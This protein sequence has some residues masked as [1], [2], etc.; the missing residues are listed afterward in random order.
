MSSS[1]KQS[2]QSHGRSELKGAVFEGGS[3]ESGNLL[4][5]GPPP[6]RNTFH[7]KT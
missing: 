4:T 2:E 1:E 6:H 3:G 7:S 5:T